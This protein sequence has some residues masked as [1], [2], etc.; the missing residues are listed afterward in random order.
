MDK[1]EVVGHHTEILAQ[2]A[3]AHNAGHI[4]RQGIK[5]GVVDG[6]PALGQRE[7]NDNGNG[8]D[9]HPHRVARN[10]VAQAGE[11]GDK[12][13]M[14]VFF[15][16]LVK[17]EDEGGQDDD[18]ADHAQRHALGHDHADV[19]A[20]RQLHGAQGQEARNGGQAGSGN[21]GGRLA[22]GVDHGFLVGG[23]QLFF[24][25]IAVEQEDG[26]IHRHAQ[27]QH[28][29]QRLGNEA[30]ILEEE[31]GAKVVHQREEQPQH[32]QKGRDG[33]LQCQEQN[34]QAGT[35]AKQ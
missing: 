32:K 24:L 22:D 26:K 12:R 20:Q 9:Q 16:P 25:F 17:E 33:A 13:A 21:G 14:T 10:K 7:G 30:D 15:H 23:G 1:D 3:H 29:G 11:L 8:R 27:L 34:E 2:L 19:P 4:L 6:S 18:G 28:G 35:A 5:Q 31:V